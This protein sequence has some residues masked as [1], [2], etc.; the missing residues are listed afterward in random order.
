M[1]KTPEIKEA[2]GRII[3]KK[4]KA[5]PDG[6]P[7]I[8]EDVDQQ[9]T[10][11]NQV[12]AS[13]P[14]KEK[15]AKWGS[16]ERQFLPAALEIM[17]TPAHP[18]GRMMAITLAAF[19]SI[20]LIWASIGEVDV[21]AVATGKIVPT[22][23]V[24]QIQALEIGT[25]RAIHVRDGQSVKQGDVLIELDPTESEVDKGQML[26]QR[27]TAMLDME[28]LE[29]NLHGLKNDDVQI[30]IPSIDVE[31]D[32]LDMARQRLETDL[33]SYQSQ[34]MALDVEY[35]RRAA[36]QETAKVEIAKLKE[37]L[38]LIEE[39]EDALSQ[40][41]KKGIAP[42]PNWLEVKQLLIETQHNVQIQ[43]N[44][45]AESEANMKAL[46]I[47]KD[48]LTS[49]TQQTIL[50]ELVEAQDQFEAANL[51]LRK[52]EK[53]ETQRKLF[54]PVD[55]VV[56]QLSVHTVGGVVSPA[57]P[58]MLVIPDD[59]P[60]EIQ[61]QVLNKD[62][63]FVEPDQSAEVK[64]DSFPFT[65]YGTID[66]TVRTL[67]RDAIIDENLG[68]VFDARISMDRTDIM[69]NGRLVQLTPGMTASI[70]VKTGKRRIIEF[71]LS[72]VM[73]HANEALRE[74]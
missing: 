7:L 13:A 39:R 26:R 74:R 61:A 73:K 20:A 10:D 19:F 34:V 66:G 5:G 9:S 3:P 21:V 27:R 48:R 69:A 35:E 4:V 49:E 33:L 25:V 53:K 47:E 31:Q 70:E 54:S 12:E 63:G 11:E 32:M 42:K 23:G 46:L 14:P 18:V 22:G 56:Q 30:G 16:E 28:R 59:A 38:P 62:A 57:E 6:K 60:L 67:S 58:I 41:V 8:E 40:L 44:R 36:E 43:Q 55:G 72:P 2:I 17:E 50:D 29:A 45:L 71:L 65:K 68:P 24:K 15:K 51:A 1:I 52:A 64:I 37:T